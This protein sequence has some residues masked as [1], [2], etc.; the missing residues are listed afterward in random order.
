MIDDVVRERE[1]DQ[2]NAAI[3]FGWNPTMARMAV[4]Q[5]ALIG[6]E[7]DMS[8]WPVIPQTPIQN[9]TTG[10][11]KFIPGISDPLGPDYL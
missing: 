11:L 1:Q 10:A 6:R 7:S 8:E 2:V 4:E 3:P 5:Q 9:Q